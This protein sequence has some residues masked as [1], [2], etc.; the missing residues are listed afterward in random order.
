MKKQPYSIEIVSTLVSGLS[1]M[2]D[3]SRCSMQRVL[4]EQ[5]EQVRITLVETLADLQAIV[6][7]NPDLIVLGMK[8]LEVPIVEGVGATRKVWLAHYF[9]RH[10]I[11]ITGS[12]DRAHQLELNKQL[13]KQQ[14]QCEGITTAPYFVV[15]MGASVPPHAL[16]FPLFVK[17]TNRGGGVGI[18]PQSLVHTTAQLRAKLDSLTKEHGS[19]A[20]VEEYLEGREFSVAVL[21]HPYANTFVAMPLEL[22]AP[23]VTPDGARF[24]SSVVKAADTETYAFV[25]NQQLREQLSDMALQSFYALGARDYGRIDLRMNGAGQLH[26]LEANLIPSLLEGYGNFPKACYLN[27]GISYERMVLRLVGLGLQRR[28]TDAAT[29]VTSVE[30]TGPSATVLMPS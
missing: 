27:K 20:L 14:V 11:A 24:L 21:K 30:F 5:Y 23:V 2:S 22:V 1:S 10:G 26:F 8:Y 19:D 9:E 28:I 25:Q 16:T 17:P 29:D 18:D 12:G 4:S 3:P 7:R 15:S 6:T 13:A